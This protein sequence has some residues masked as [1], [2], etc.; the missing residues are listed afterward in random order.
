MQ[1]PNYM[2]L[3][4]AAEMTVDAL[5]FSKAAVARM[6]RNGIVSALQL[7]ELAVRDP[8][9]L[10]AATGVSGTK[11]IRLVVEKLGPLRDFQ[12]VA[13]TFDVIST[14]GVPLQEPPAD[15]AMTAASGAPED[16]IAALIA[17]RTPQLPSR[18][19]LV[20]KMRPIG[21]QGPHG[22][23]VGWAANA[24]HEYRLGRQMSPGY[25]YRGAKSRDNYPGEGSWLRF[26]MQHGFEI[27]HVDEQSYPYTAAI[28]E[29]PISPLAA[30]AGQNRTMGHVSLLG[31]KPEQVAGL[32]KLALCGELH[33]DLGPMPVAVSVKLYESFV[34]TSTALDGLIR[35]PLPGEK[36]RGGHAMCVVGYIDAKDPE[37]PFGIDYF[38]VRNSWGTT[39]GCHNPF[40]LAGHAMIPSQYF[41]N[42]YLMEAMVN[43][44]GGLR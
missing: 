23:C 43:I 42:H 21:N 22:T 28:R 26:A 38:A 27:G 9:Q 19:L 15:L 25:A 44:G 35:M 29:Q 37:N 14:S 36:L 2:S 20:E 6:K 39:W 1:E 4:S 5:G 16:Q 18:K 12:N 41:N 7:A 24:T 11:A 33:D 40:G 30:L 34:S 32:I 10:K 8:R 3:P 13:T 17:A 31:A